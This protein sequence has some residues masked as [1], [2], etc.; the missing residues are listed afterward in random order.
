MG[1]A[2]GYQVIAFWQEFL[3]RE[4]LSQHSNAKIILLRPSMAFLLMQTQDSQIE[5][6]ASALPSFDGVTHIFLPINDCSNASV[7]EGGSHWS[8]LLV[9]AVDGVAFHYDSMNSANGLEAEHATRK[10]ARI[11]KKEL[12]FLDL[13]DSPQQANSSDCGVFVC[14]TMKHLLLNRLLTTSKHQQAPMSMGG[15]TVNAASGRKEI[16][17]VIENFRREGERRRS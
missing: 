13:E 17:R 8:L 11:L 7:A 15:R 16:L 10:M 6:A 12:R 3:E 9:S 2:N 14:L 5:V 4:L 1:C